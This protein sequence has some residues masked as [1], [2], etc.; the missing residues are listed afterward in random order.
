MESEVNYY[1]LFTRINEEMTNYGIG[2]EQ[3][4]TKE[5]GNI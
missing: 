2:W 1:K 5:R 4:H 3:E